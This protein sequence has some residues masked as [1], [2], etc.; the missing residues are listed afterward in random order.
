MNV[1]LMP[2]YKLFT[3]L[4]LQPT[5]IAG[6]LA[7]YVLYDLIHYFIHHASPEDGYWKDIKIYHMQ[8]HY[9]SDKVGYGVSQKFWD[10]VFNTEIK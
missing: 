8:H 4:W 10:L 9:K 5:L 6:T 7:G 3:P 1:I 2:F